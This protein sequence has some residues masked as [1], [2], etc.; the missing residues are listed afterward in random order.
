[1]CRCS[2]RPRAGGEKA[3]SMRLNAIAAQSKFD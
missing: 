3:E 1:V 2:V